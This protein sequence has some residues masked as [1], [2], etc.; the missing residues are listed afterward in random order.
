[1]ATEVEL[2]GD[3]LKLPGQVRVTFIRTLRLPE[4]GT[5]PLPPGLGSFPLRR[6]ADYPETVPEQ[7]RERGGVMLP[8]Y[9]REA[10]WLRFSAHA[11][12]ALKVGVGKVCAISGKP[13]SD[14]L[15]GKPQNYV[16]LPQQPWLDGINSGKGTVRQFVAMPLGLGATVEGQVT[17]SEQWGGIQVAV[18]T[19]TETARAAWEA[20]QRARSARPTPVAY[21][22]VPPPA[23][24]GAAPSPA[25]S[26]APARPGSAPTARK[27][28]A[29]GLGAGGTMR[30]EIYTDPRP[31][32]DY[33]SEADGRIFVHLVS[34][35]EWHEITGEP[36][37]STPVTAH[38]YAEHGLPWFDYYDSD[39]EDLPPSDDLAAVRPTGDWLTDEGHNPVPDQPLP[40]IQLG[41]K[42]V[43]DGKW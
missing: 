17:G 19:L 24:A 5:Y 11:P 20:E 6:V 1:M 38:S 7:W 25:Y 28:R 12:A 34:A 4:T 40:V 23:P 39:A 26:A 27:A 9:Q 21:G 29:M 18:H 16:P 8:V 15:V 36:A 37:P 3:A 14:T 42:P 31:V 30:Q 43:Q 32:T 22:A 10:M 35:A 2:V 41:D 13:W 33:R